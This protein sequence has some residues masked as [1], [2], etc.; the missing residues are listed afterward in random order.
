MKRSTSAV[1][2]IATIAGLGTTVWSLSTL[3]PA[4]VEVLDERSAVTARVIDRPDLIDSWTGVARLLL[5][6]ADL[7]GAE[8]TD[9]EVSAWLASLDPAWAERNAAEAMIWYALSHQ[10]AVRAGASRPE[11]ADPIATEVRARAIDLLI[12]HSQAH[13]A[14]MRHWHWNSLAWAWLRSGKFDATA[15]ALERTES[16]ILSLPAP[17]PR[18]VVLA[19]LDR[20]ASCWG[21]NGLGDTEKAR[22]VYRR[23]ERLAQEWSPEDPPVG[24]TRLDL[25]ERLFRLGDSESG[26]AILARFE[27]HLRDLPEKADLR[28]PWRRVAALLIGR[29]DER[30]VAALDALSAQLDRHGEGAGRLTWNEQGW[31]Y[32]NLGATDKAQQAW[33]KWLAI[34]RGLVAADETGDTLY[35]LACGLALTGDVTGALDALERARQKGWGNFRY[36]RMDRDLVPLHDEPRF[37]ALLE[38]LRARF[39]D[40][41]GVR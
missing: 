39:L 4:R 30:A 11:F 16:A 1:L 14:S 3:D 7:A 40:A 15:G 19:G 10:L 13:P 37:T 23:A 5:S 9:A 21:Q 22:G 26:L 32:Q 24:I 29:D 34:Q 12:R 6:D 20:L 18:S 25:V 35:N 36:A 8:T 27:A 2:T 33:E 41:Q 28:P 38:D 17:T 31:L